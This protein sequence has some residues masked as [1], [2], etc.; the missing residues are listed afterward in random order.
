M[1]E[2]EAFST[3]SI[4][5]KVPRSVSNREWKVS[6]EES[7]E[8]AI[9]CFW[10]RESFLMK[11]QHVKHVFGFKGNSWEI[12]KLENSINIFLD[13]QTDRNRE[14]IA[15]WRGRQ[16]ENKLQRK[17]NENRLKR[18]GRIEASFEYIHCCVL[19]FRAH[20]RC[21]AKCDKTKLLAFVVFLQGSKRKLVKEIRG[22]K[23]FCCLFLQIEFVY[24]LQLGLHCRFQ[25]K[26]PVTI[27]GVWVCLWASPSNMENYDYVLLL[28]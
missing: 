23:S 13:T 19:Y 6:V 7:R 14:S 18:R 21:E 26:L 24:M 8:E 9:K 22:K 25:F 1:N 12:G 11:I 3:R 28:L 4:S 20:S 2:I 5:W 15:N 10:F 27:V 16:N 17:E